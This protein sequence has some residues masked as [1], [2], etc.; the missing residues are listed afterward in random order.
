[1]IAPH[2]DNGLRAYPSGTLKALARRAYAKWVMLVEPALSPLVKAALGKSPQM[3]GR[4]RHLRDRLRSG[5]AEVLEIFS[6]VVDKL[7]RIYGRCSF[8]L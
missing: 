7:W 8:G 3:L 6:F 5:A 4:V 1:M 2:A